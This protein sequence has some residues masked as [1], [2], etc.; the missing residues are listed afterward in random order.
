MTTT[1]KQLVSV[2]LSPPDLARIKRIAKRLAVRE[3]DVIRFAIK[4]MLTKLAP[5]HDGLNGSD[6]LPAFIEL[7]AELTGYFELDSTQVSAIVN[8]DDA[9]VTKKISDEDIKLLAMTALPD[10]YLHARLRE[11]TRLPVEA[12]GLTTA[13]RLYLYE[14]YLQPASPPKGSHEPSE[15]NLTAE[16]PSQPPAHGRRSGIVKESS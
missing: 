5:L 10:H 3:S 15:P 7:G 11:L 2:R 12:V 16:W 14:K 8:N 9:P 4:S 6:V 1:N 13:L